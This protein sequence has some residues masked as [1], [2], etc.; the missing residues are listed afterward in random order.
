MKLKQFAAAF[1]L[2][3]ALL[4]AGC[5]RQDTPGTEE[6]T[7]PETETSPAA[8]ALCLWKDNATDYTIIRRDEALETDAEYMLALLL[9]DKFREKFDGKSPRVYSDYLDRGQSVP[10]DAC[11]IVIGK[12]N[13][14]ASEETLASLHGFAYAIR[15]SGSRV[16]ICGTNDVMLSLA[17]NRFID[18]FLSPADGTLTVPADTNIVF[19][20]LELHAEHDDAHAGYRDDT[21]CIY[22]AANCYAIS[23]EYS[24]TVNGHS[25]PVVENTV[26]F[27]SCAFAFSGTAEIA[28]TVPGA[29]SSC[30]VSPLSKEYA[31][32][33]NG[34]TIT[35]TLTEP[36]HLIL[37]IPGKKKKLVIAADAPETNV[38]S[39]TDENVFLIGGADY[40]ADPTGNLSAQ[41][42]LQSAIDRAG[43]S[44]GTV[45]VPDG[46][47]TFEQLRL[48]SN[49][50]IYLAPG[51]VL[52]ANSDPSRIPVSYRRSPDAISPPGGFD[53]TFL[54][55][56]TPDKYYENIRICGR[57]TID[58]QGL[59]LLAKSR[60]I[61]PVHPVNVRGFTMEG[62][63]IR[64]GSHWSTMPVNCTGVTI[65]NTKHLNDISPVSSENDAIDVVCC[66]DVV[67]RNVL[68]ISE[69]DAIS[70]K[71]YTAEAFASYE[72]WMGGSD[73]QDNVNILATDCL[74]WTVCG[75]YKI[76]WGVS[77][78]AKDITFRNCSAFSAMT[79]IDITLK[80][81]SGEVDGI[82]FE[83]VDIERFSPRVTNDGKTRKCQFFM[84]RTESETGN[85]IRN[86]TLRNISARTSWDGS[87]QLK[88]V[89]T[90]SPVTGVHFENITL[91]G[92]QYKTLAS[93][94]RPG[95]NTSDITLSAD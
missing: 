76:G 73:S 72:G 68:A 46:I 61:S 53:G 14:S 79:G 40:P 22:P 87:N 6:S 50:T 65:E 62:I 41:K 54:I 70:V 52:R 51:A 25:V 42:V 30:S 43:T 20:T 89:S 82:L 11:E 66:Q 31:A 19:E 44:G 78:K 17:V 27:D 23:S 59:A 4:S 74:A 35:L 92:K 8:P 67:I 84:I 3:A 15:V 95:E 47:F 94:V 32:A 34:S 39:P 7:M 38:P 29:V 86:V 88:G 56:T 10:E 49:V 91:R 58:G 69:D 5:V 26:D 24:L 80:H 55:T 75:A 21:L 36:D 9:R 28:V 81:G 64:D 60:L 45:Y 71:S 85:G 12:T 57:G 63:T 2:A 16:M 77:M 83:N 33:V 48:C 90:S 13:R 18:E 1:C 93:L 37:E